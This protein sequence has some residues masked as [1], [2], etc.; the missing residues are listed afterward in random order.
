VRATRQCLPAVVVAATMAAA[1]R[2]I[3]MAAAADHRILI[4]F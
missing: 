1:E 4:Q 2:I 3:G